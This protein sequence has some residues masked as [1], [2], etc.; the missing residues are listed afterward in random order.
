ML[1]S[2]RSWKRHSQ[3][4]SKSQILEEALSKWQQV[5]DPG[6]G[7]LMVLSSRS[8]RRHFN[9]TK[10]QILDEALSWY[11][12]PDPG[13]GTLMVLSSRQILEEVLSWGQ[14]QILEEALSWYHV[15]DPGRGTHMVLKCQLEERSTPNRHFL[16]QQMQQKDIL[17]L[18]LLFLLPHPHCKD[19]QHILFHCK[20][21]FLFYLLPV[22]VLQ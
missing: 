14:F 19:A 20:K 1:P 9:G 10:S 11:Q 3:N 16:G 21:I 15:P 6:R 5:P 8:Q 13:R 2:P 22:S 12:V 7:T 17:Q 18:N 4:G